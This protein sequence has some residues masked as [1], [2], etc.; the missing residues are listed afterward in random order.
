MI[1]DNNFHTVN[2]LKCDTNINEQWKDILRLKRECFAEMDYDEHREPKL[3][4][5]SDIIKT[6]REE[7]KQRL[8]QEPITPNLMYPMMTMLKT[9]LSS[10]SKTQR[11]SR[12]PE[13]NYKIFLFKGKQ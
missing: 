7:R 6:F 12:Q 4:L 1:F 2:S 13:K 3:P 10:K 8:L 5:L 9:K 11:P